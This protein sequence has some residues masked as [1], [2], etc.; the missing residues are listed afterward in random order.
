MALKVLASDKIA[1][2]GLKMLRDAG[3]QADMKTKLPEDELCKVISDYDALIV[4]SGTKVTPKVIESAGKLKIIG[5]AGVGVDN[6]DLPSA[7][8]RGII[9]V[10]SPEGNTIAAAEQT[11]TLILAMARNIPQA[12]NSLRAGKWERSKFTGTELFNKVVGVVGLG[13]IGGRVASYLNAMEAKVIGSDPF[14]S[15]ERAKELGIELK[16]LDEV[17]AQADI[18]TFHIPKTKDT[19]NLINSRTISKMKDGVFLVNCARG[20]IIDE[21][22][23]YDALKSGKVKA[24]ALDVFSKEPPDPKNPLFTLDNVV[25]VPHLGAATLEAQE[26]VAIDVVEQIIEVLK[27]GQ[28]RSAVNIPAMKPDIIAKV[29]P[30]MQLAEKLGSLASQ[31]FGEALNEVKIEYDG[32]IAAMDVSPLSIA[33]LKG[34][35]EP[36]LQESVNFVNAPVIAKERGIKVIEGK[37]SE[38]RDFKNL[39][40]VKVKSGKDTRSV[41]GTLFEPPYGERLVG[42]DGF[43]VDV[44]PSGYMLVINNIDKPG[45]IGKVGTFLGKHGINIAAMDVGR[46]KIGEKAVMVLNVDSE[47]PDKAIKE[48]TK[49]EGIEGATLVV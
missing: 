13:K 27:G 19:E 22:D 38:P 35:L 46:V 9:V 40:T 39:I 32:E 2:S 43:K 6:V 33:A 44:M 26:N 30:Y 16:S 15:Q 8:K 1:E 25:T 41:E 5:R 49:L 20:G 45:I 14:I 11:L 36:M 47:I 7:T 23:L 24:A 48:L 37:S 42:I 4:R 10:N 34:L 21:K 29:K 31:L 17:M 3:L 28:A 12:Y 18:L